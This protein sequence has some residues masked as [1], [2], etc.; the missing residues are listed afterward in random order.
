MKWYLNWD[1][2]IEKRGGR[3]GRFVFQAE[4]ASTLTSC[5]REVF[6]IEEIKDGSTQS[7]LLLPGAKGQAWGWVKNEALTSAATFKGMPKNSVINKDKYFNAI[8]KKSQ[9]I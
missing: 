9:L 5:F 7:L 2:T 6:P 3:Q 1:L 8:F 4:G